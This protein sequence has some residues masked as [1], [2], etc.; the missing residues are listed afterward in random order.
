M[1]SAKSPKP[2]ARARA[3]GRLLLGYGAACLVAWLLFVLAGTE[4]QRGLWQLWEAVYQA[5][6]TLW[7]PMLIGLGVLPLAQWLA[8]RERAL[9]LQLAVHVGGALLFSLAWLVW[10]TA[11]PGCCSVPNMPTPRWSRASCGGRSGACWSM[12]CCPPASQQ[13]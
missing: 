11:R 6:L 2:P 12:P 10:T 3:G 5:T 4:F 1:S 9:P 7:A 8:R 13:P